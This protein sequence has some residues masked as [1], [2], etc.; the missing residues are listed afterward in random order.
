MGSGEESY[1]Y[2]KSEADI[3]T[4][5][6][7]GLLFS[8]NNLSIDSDYIAL[9]SDLASFMSTAAANA[10]FSTPSSVSTTI[11]TTLSGTVWASSVGLGTNGASQGLHFN[12]NLN[13]LY[14]DDANGRLTELVQLDLSV[15]HQRI[16]TPRQDG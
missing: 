12:W 10:T 14:L 1:G 4:I 13:G 2:S 9:K 7:S 5:S 16:G 15:T 6:G 8:N 3:I 11:I